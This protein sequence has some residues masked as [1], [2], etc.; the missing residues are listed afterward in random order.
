MDKDINIEDTSMDK[1]TITKR[2][3]GILF[4]NPKIENQIRA[5]HGEVSQT[6]ME[7]IVKKMFPDKFK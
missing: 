6:A 1:A 4:S 2:V 5:K 3:N 7:Q